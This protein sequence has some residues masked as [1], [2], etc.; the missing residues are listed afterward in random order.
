MYETKKNARIR[1]GIIISIVIVINLFFSMVYFRIDFT[2][3]KRYTLSKTTKD[4]LK[5]LKAPVTVTA[6]FSDKLPPDVLYIKNDFRDLLIEYKSFSRNKVVYSFVDPSKDP[7]VKQKVIQKGIQPM[8]LNIR[9]KDRFQQQEV[10]MGAIVQYGDKMEVIPALQPGAPMEYALTFAINKCSKKEKALIGLVQGQGEASLRQISYLQEVLSDLYEI[11][12]FTLTDST[13]IPEKYKAIAIINPTDSFT[14]AQLRELDSYTGAGG[15]LLLAYSLVKGDLSQMPPSTFLNA[16]GIENWLK[17]YNIDLLPS[18]VYD[19]QSSQITV[20]QRQGNYVISTPVDFFY[21]PFFSR[22]GDHPVTKGLESVILPFVSE[23]RTGQPPAGVK[24]TPLLMT[25]DKSGTQAVPFYIDL[26][27]QWK[28]QDFNRS[29]IPIAIAVEGSKYGNKNA[30]MVIVTNGEFILNDEQGRLQGAPDN[31]NFMAGAI[32]W[33]S[34]ETGLADL[35]TKTIHTRMLKQIPDKRKNTIKYV[36]V[37]LPV[38]LVIFYGILR[39]RTQRK[40][41][42]FINQ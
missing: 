30:K 19:L 24:I 10:F 14:E 35:R 27:R 20:Q 3:D 11:E 41:R 4:I 18:M 40:R 15:R 2:A 16:T 36:N 32:D 38:L 31:L 37:L 7:R 1:L 28:D 12:E 17:D 13:E 8:L 5:N 34:D 9:K 29:N 26:L 21:I 25:S 23:I 33:L 42:Q 6:Y 39:A 22:F